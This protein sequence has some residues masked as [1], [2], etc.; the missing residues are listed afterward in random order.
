[1]CAA[2]R[3]NCSHVNCCCL[4]GSDN[5]FTQRTSAV[6]HVVIQAGIDV[7]DG[8]GVRRKMRL[9]RRP[10]SALRLP[11]QQRQQ[12]AQTETIPGIHRAFSVK[13]LLVGVGGRSP[14]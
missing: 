12:E 3:Q 9:R 10:A 13:Y 7:D 6:G 14:V 1:M 8:I 4:F 11:H 2:A 5:R